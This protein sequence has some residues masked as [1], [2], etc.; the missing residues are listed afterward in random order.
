MIRSF[1]QSINSQDIVKGS[2]QQTPPLV[3]LQH[4]PCQVFSRHCLVMRAW[5]S[6]WNLAKFYEMSSKSP[7]T[8]LHT[9]RRTLESLILLFIQMQGHGEALQSQGIVYRQPSLL[10]PAVM[11]QWTRNSCNSLSFV[12]ERTFPVFFQHFWRH[13]SAPRG[14]HAA[15]FKSRYQQGLESIS[16]AAIGHWDRLQ[17]TEKP[18]GHA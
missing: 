18:F 14:E 15:L 13:R 10:T 16:A 9:C 6:I 3:L 7:E 11:L 4:F 2:F 5:A 8:I 12:V 1:K 17:V